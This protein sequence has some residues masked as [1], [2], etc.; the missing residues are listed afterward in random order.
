M[1]EMNSINELSVHLISNSTSVT[2]VLTRFICI[3]YTVCYYSVV[4]RKQTKYYKVGCE[5]NLYVP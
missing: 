1:N 3:L 2:I 5:G 4:F